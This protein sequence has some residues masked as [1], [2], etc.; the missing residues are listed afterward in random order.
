VQ[1]KRLFIVGAG[2]FG[3]EAADVA[4]RVSG[5]SPV[6]SRWL[7][8]GVYDDRPSAENLQR[9]AKRALPYLGPIPYDSSQTGRFFVVGIGNPTVRQEIALRLENRGWTAATLI[10]PDASIGTD[11]RV[12]PGTVV[13]G[14]VQV[15][16]NVSLG[17]HVHLNPNSTIGHDTSLE[18]YVSVNPAATVSGE[19]RVG[20]GTLIGAASVI[21]QGL[22]VGEEVIVGAA[23]C[24][25]RDV[26]RGSVVK[27]VPAR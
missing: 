27:G 24:V 18:D 26:P 22:S 17:R 19:V 8:E 25:V 6:D 23:A 21:L 20:T 13:C 7:V 14:G 15:S 12:Q 5:C 2:G 1:P 11:V 10:H 3:R 16:T 4:E 9:L